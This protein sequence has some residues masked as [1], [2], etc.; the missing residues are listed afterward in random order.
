M[1]KINIFMTSLENS[2]L[3]KPS[4]YAE[5]YDRSLLFR[6]EREENRTKYR[7]DAANLPFVG[8]D[9][10]NAYEISF[11]TDQGLPV[12]RVMKMKYDASS[13]FMV[14]SK[15]LKLYLN[16]FNM[17]PCGA[18]QE[19]AAQ[20][21]KKTIIDDLSS[22]LETEVAVS[23]FSNDSLQ[24]SAF[25]GFPKL[26]QLIPVSDLEAIRFN[27]FH[28]SPELLKGELTKNLQ[29]FTFCSDLLRSNC[30]VTNQPDWGD[31]FVK[32]SSPYQLD[33]TSILSYLVSFRREN[34]FHEA[35]TEMIFQRFMVVFQPAELMVATMYTRRGGIDINPIRA[36]HTSLID[37][38]FTAMDVMLGKNLR[39]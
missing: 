33:W 1:Q 15:S 32:I 34:H 28:E 6:I 17:E 2:Q 37:E 23:F 29:T 30:P 21:V 8:V 24:L 9:V 4:Q 5:R 31:L 13:K 3:G 27:H 10:W 38:A 39:Q 26:T 19:E 11:L 35:V 16:S 22:L 18:T 12:S 14:E 36:T 20:K 25:K 7:I